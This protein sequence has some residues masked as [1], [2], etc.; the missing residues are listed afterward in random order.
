M[1][2]TS[3]QAKSVITAAEAKARSLGVPVVVAVLDP[4]THLVAFARMDGAPLASVD[5]ALRKART[6]A[7]FG[8]PSE[9]VWEYCRPGAP[10]P[11]LELTNGGLA[12]YGG[13]VPLNDESGLVGSVGVSGGAIAQDRQVAQVAAAA[14]AVARSHR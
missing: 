4:G 10:A 2:L 9:Q 14:F 7:L 8:I 3:E 13:G 5:I 12:P 11:A 6:A 1:P